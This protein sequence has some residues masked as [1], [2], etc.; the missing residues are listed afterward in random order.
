MGLM[1]SRKSTVSAKAVPASC[2]RACHDWPS[3]A[4]SNA[5]SEPRLPTRF[6]TN[7]FQLVCRAR[8]TAS[9]A[10]PAVLTVGRLCPGGDGAA[11]TGGWVEAPWWESGWR[12]PTPA[13][14]PQ[15]R[16]GDVVRAWGDW[17]IRDG[18]CACARPRW[19]WSSGTRR[20][21][22]AGDR[23][24]GPFPAWVPYTAA[25]VAASPSGPN[26][27][28]GHQCS[29]SSARAVT[30]VA[31]AAPSLTAA[32]S[33]PAASVVPEDPATRLSGTSPSWSCALVWARRP[34]CESCPCRR[35]RVG[36]SRAAGIR[37]GGEARAGLRGNRSQGPRRHPPTIAGCAQLPCRVRSS[38]TST[39]PRAASTAC[40]MPSSPRGFVEP[41]AFQQRKTDSASRAERARPDDEAEEQD[42]D[43]PGDRD[44]GLH[45]RPRL[46][47]LTDGQAEV[48]LTSQKPASLTWL[49]KS[50]PAPT[51]STSRA[52][53]GLSSPAARGETIPAAVIVATVAEPVARRMPTAINQ[54]RDQGTSPTLGE[55][56]DDR[57][58]AGV[59]EHLLEAPPGNT[60]SRMP[61]MPATRCPPTSRF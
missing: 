46:D 5:T 38:T 56:T 53:V 10:R 24:A 50:E 20:G 13:D 51:A 14:P 23:P 6:S 2:A 35:V 9:P 49:K 34:R 11:D 45:D 26:C 18:H 43:Q 27:G 47:R 31:Q 25:A 19:R 59:D 58:D 30:G 17:A 42:E 28:G 54:P 3:R 37:G 52:R 57:T 40:S 15:H 32:E 33:R 55:V 12:W 36:G 61:A 41:F 16:P 7:A 39:R 29:S 1:I 4:S 8:P 44:H 60:M 22:A 48:L 21:A